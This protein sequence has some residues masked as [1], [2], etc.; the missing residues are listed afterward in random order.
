MTIEHDR[1]KP[2]EPK[3]GT[4]KLLGLGEVELTARLFS[5]RTLFAP[6]EPPPEGG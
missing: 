4:F 6:F 2:R 1:R 5:A 3:L